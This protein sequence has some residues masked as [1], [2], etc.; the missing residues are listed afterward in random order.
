MSNRQA[1]VRSAI[2]QAYAGKPRLLTVLPAIMRYER[3]CRNCRWPVAAR[4]SQPELSH[5]SRSK[6]DPHRLDLAGT[7][8]QVRIY[9]EGKGLY[10]FMHAGR[11]ILASLEVGCVVASDDRRVDNIA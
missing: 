9:R 3:E 11:T 1:L 8:R 4:K 5:P 2:R 6:S 7:P 10:N